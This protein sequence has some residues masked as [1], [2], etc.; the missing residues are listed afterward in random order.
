AQSQGDQSQSQGDLAETQGDLSAAQ[1]DQYQTQG[2]QTEILGDMSQSQ[3]GGTQGD[4]TQGDQTQSLAGHGGQTQGDQNQ[5]MTG[6]GGQT[7][8]D[9]TLSSSPTISTPVNVSGVNVNV[10]VSCCDECKKH[11]KNDFED[12][13]IECRRTITSLL[14]LIRT[15]SLAVANPS[16]SQ[17]EFYSCGLQYLPTYGSLG[18]VTDCTF[19]VV[20]GSDGNNITVLTDTLEALSFRPVDT[21][22]NLFSLLLAYLQSAP[23][24]VQDDLGKCGSDSRDC[25]DKELQLLLQTYCLSDT[26]IQINLAKV[27][28]TGYIYKISNGIVYLVDDLTT[29]TVIYA[30]P[31]CRILSYQPQ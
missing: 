10:T 5:T 18:N 7:L 21:T 11:R 3:G 16:A 30:I 1:G 23:D 31:L 22:P 12:C 27:S 4:Q 25:C 14:N 20:P 28:F 9:Q 19:T 17:V 24:C 13:K 29:P 6:H 2:D 15:F 26:Q 8:G